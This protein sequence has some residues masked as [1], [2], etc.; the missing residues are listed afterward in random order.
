MS[1]IF[2]QSMELI[3]A[4]INQNSVKVDHTFL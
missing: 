3:N 2:P 4:M 1:N